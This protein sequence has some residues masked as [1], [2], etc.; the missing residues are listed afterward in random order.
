MDSIDLDQDGKR[1]A[2]AIHPDI[3]K[4]M[5][6]RIE[7]RELGLSCSKGS[8]KAGIVQITKSK[9]VIVGCVLEDG[10]YQPAIIERYALNQYIFH[11]PFKDSSSPTL[12][13]CDLNAS[14]RLFVLTRLATFDTSRV[15]RLLAAVA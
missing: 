10:G 12:S 1:A 11:L 5:C 4:P 15:A 7:S 14:I 8:L 2:V 13:A 3:H 9:N 6:D